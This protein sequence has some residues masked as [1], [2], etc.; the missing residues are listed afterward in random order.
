MGKR[1]GWIGDGGHLRVYGTMRRMALLT[2]CFT[3]PD[4]RRPDSTNTGA[5]GLI[6]DGN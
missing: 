6:D 4:A 1:M 5:N 3:D 2:I